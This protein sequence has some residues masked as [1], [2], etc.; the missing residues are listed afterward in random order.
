MKEAAASDLLSATCATRL[1]SDELGYVIVPLPE[2]LASFIQ[3]KRSIVNT[4]HPTLGI[5]T[6]MIYDGFHHMW[7]DLQMFV[8]D[9]HHGPP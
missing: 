1:R 7:C 9:G 8:H 5:A 4:S 2:G 6:D 3:I